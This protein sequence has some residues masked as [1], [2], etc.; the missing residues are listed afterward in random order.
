MTEQ[1]IHAV[2][3]HGGGFAY[4]GKQPFQFRTLRV[5]AR[6]PFGIGESD[7]SRYAGIALFFVQR[8]LWCRFGIKRIST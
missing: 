6:F 7:R 8:K 1:P 4:E 3:H 2:H 5:L